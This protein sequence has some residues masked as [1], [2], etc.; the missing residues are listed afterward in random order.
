MLVR[1]IDVETSGL[2]P[3]L[4]RIVEV[5]TV[6]IHVS[7]GPPDSTPDPAKAAPLTVTRGRMWSSLV[8][9][10]M[11]IPPEASAIHDITD[12]MV[13]NAPTLADVMPIITESAP[14][15]VCAHHNRFDMKF[16]H[17]NG[18][19]WLDTYRIALWLWPEA[20]NHKNSTL[21][22]WLKLN[23]DP[24]VISA[25]GNRSHSALWDAYVTGAI[26]RRAIMSGATIEDMLRVSSQPALLP[27]LG[28]GKHAMDSIVDVPTGYLS[29]ILDQQGMEEDII[30]TARTEMARRRD[31]ERGWGT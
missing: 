29:W 21:R 28:F 6:D 3:A 24:A 19:Q 7:L 31:G 8:N 13:A 23:L 30:H 4:D 15:L 17:Q 16:I 10:G 26:L 25:P 1:V 14:K 2:D 5:G 27:R 22:Y 20:P 12:E 11:P 18:W 9:P